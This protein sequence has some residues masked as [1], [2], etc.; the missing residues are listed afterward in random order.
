MRLIKAWGIQASSQNTYCEFSRV[1]GHRMNV[2]SLKQNQATYILRYFLPRPPY[3]NS[4]D[5]HHYLNKLIQFCR[6]NNVEAVQ[7]YCNFH[8]DWYYMPDQ[9][10]HSIQW[11]EEMKKTAEACREAH[12]S[13][14]LNFQV[15]LGMHTGGTDMRSRYDWEYL[16]NHRGEEV[17]GCG[18]PLGPKFREA[19]G[20]VIRAWAETKPDVIWFDDDLRLHNHSLMHPDW[21]C[22]CPIHLRL[23]EERTGSAYRPEQLFKLAFGSGAVHPVRSEWLSLLNETMT[24]TASWIASIVHEVSPHT[25]NAQM[26][27]NPEIHSL[28]GR[29]WSNYLSAISGS[30]HRPLLRPFFGPYTEGPPLEFISSYTALDQL[31]ANVRQQVKQKVDYC[32]EIE[33]TRFTRWAK[34]TEATR[35]QLRLGGLMGCPGI[36]LSLFDLEGTPLEEEPGYAQLLREEKQLLNQLAL[37]QL[38]DWKPRG[39]GIFTDAEMGVKIECEEDGQDPQLA[40][41]FFAGPGHTWSSQLLQMGIPVYHLNVE[42]KEWPE[43]IALDGVSAQLLPNDDILRI[44][45]GSVLLDAHAACILLERGYGDLIGVCELERMQHMTSA[46]LFHPHVLQDMPGGRMPLRLRAGHWFCLTLMENARMLSTIIDAQGERYPGT[47]LYENKLGGK[48]AIYAGGND[49]GS[50]FH[51]H[52]RIRWSESLLNWLS[53]ST[54]PIFV[55]AE[56]RMLMIRRDCDESIL[57]AI[58]NLSA[59]R[60][61][62]ISGTIN[63]VGHFRNVFRLQQNGKWEKLDL[64]D[65]ISAQ[66]K[67]NNGHS[68]RLSVDLSLYQWEIIRIDRT[69]VPRAVR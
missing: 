66:A 46:E 22:Y 4:G 49:L 14:Q 47:V 59:D 48:T 8:P 17:E 20:P 13:Y 38:A 28:E 30:R 3:V 32:P 39:L 15:T 52:Q 27:S 63:D 43:V 51:N 56:Q 45:R 42:E 65:T 67:E 12:I 1:G 44:L 41:S 64:N 7:F 55:K 19:M 16:I 24:D 11:A 58:A 54:F 50:E 5:T 35:Y 26:V 36:T 62:T 34:S 33:N 2:W 6:S 10:E 60:L 23:F 61:R 18:C 25:R 29:N 57:F 40:R 21:Y 9:P 31:I 68:F 37:L 69:Q 53:N